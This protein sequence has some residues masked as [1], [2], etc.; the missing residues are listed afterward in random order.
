M[1]RSTKAKRSNTTGAVA[2]VE[3]DGRDEA[4]RDVDV[5][6]APEGAGVSDADD[7]PVEAVASP[8]ARSGGDVRREDALPRIGDEFRQLAHQRRFVREADLR[9]RERP[10]PDAPGASASPGIDAGQA[11][12]DAR[13]MLAEMARM[14]EQVAT[15]REGLGAATA[16][17]TRAEHAL[18]G[19]DQRVLAARALVQESQRRAHA[20]AERCAWLEGRCDSLETALDRAVHASFIER[21]R[22]RRRAARA[23]STPT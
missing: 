10:A 22:W 21:W 3:R 9:P 6:I 15:A 20:A 4:D 11:R 2:T 14:A 16:R 5:P 13:A 23:S 8:T 18:A 19:A 7:V 17:A 1:A 12:A